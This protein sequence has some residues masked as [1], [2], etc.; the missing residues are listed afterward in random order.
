MTT[1][2]TNTEKV[3]KRRY[4]RLEI[5]SP[6]S[7]CVVQIDK[8]KRVRTHPEKKAGVLLNISGGGALIS[9]NDRVGNDDL[10][11]L[12]FDIKGFNQLSNVL[13]RV[14]RVEECEDGER[15]IGLEFLTS[16][17]VDDP[18]LADNLS[19]LPGNPMG[20]AENLKRIVSRF[21]FQ[22]QIEAETE[23]Q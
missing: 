4:V 7:F 11:L 16:E 18:T 12:T 8:D 20:F 2:T 6:V 15:L 19:R 1:K 9:S 17:Q 14:K 13:A 3:Q 5:F 21:V 22:K 10:L 23:D